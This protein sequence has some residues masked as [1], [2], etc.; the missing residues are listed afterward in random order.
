[1][2]KGLTGFQLKMIGI[3]LM[4]FDHIHQMFILSG[5]PSW[6]NMLGRPVAII[7]IFL[8]VEGFTHTK[9]KLK[10][11]RNLLVAYWIMFILSN[12]LGRLLPSENILMNSIFGTL[13]L[14][15][16]V[17]YIAEKIITGIREKN[18]R[19]LFLGCSIFVLLI[20]L[21]FLLEMLSESGNCILLTVS[22]FI[23][24]SILAVEGGV[25]Y[26]VLALLLYLLRKYRVAQMSIIV[27]LAFVATEF[28]FTNLFTT[29]FSWMLVFSIIPI[30][31][32]NG[33]KGKS[34]KYFFYIFYPAHI[35]VLYIAAYIYQHI[36]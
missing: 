22:L 21:F 10:Y 17:M 27:L 12:I 3:I 28:N 30:Y 32:Y 18:S 15:V 29:N 36:L 6:M 20:L 8:S 26:V 19:Y 11:M 14:C 7:F 34:M 33:E 2:K 35:Y 5:A 1:M 13:F 31:L 4:V 24:P 25:I 23:F 9:N 16:L